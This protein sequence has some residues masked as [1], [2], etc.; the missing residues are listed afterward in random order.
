MYVLYLFSSI[1]AYIIVPISSLG[2]SP[3]SMNFGLN[4]I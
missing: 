2:E 3:T 4:I 1:G